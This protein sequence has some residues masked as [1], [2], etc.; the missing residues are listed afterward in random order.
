[1][2][3]FRYKNL[4]QG[5]VHSNQP[6]VRTGD[7]Y[8][9]RNGSAFWQI[10]PVDFDESKV[11]GWKFH[12]SIHPDDVSRAWDLIQERLVEEKLAAK[13]T[14]PA[15]SR[16]FANPNELQRGKMVTIYDDTS[17]PRDWGQLLKHIEDTFDKNNVRPGPQVNI[18]RPVEG[19]RFASYRNDRDLN[20]QYIDSC[21]TTSY[22][23]ANHPDP[24]DTLDLRRVAPAQTAAPRPEVA[25]LNALLAPM[26]DRYQAAQWA[27]DEG[28]GGIGRPNLRFRHP[29][30]ARTHEL[31]AS[32]E[33]VGVPSLHAQKGGSHMLV[34]W[35]DDAKALTADTLKRA[36]QH[37]A[38]T[39]VY[40][41]VARNPEGSP[42]AAWQVDA[43][44]GGVGVPNVRA[45]VNSADEA[46][47]VAARVYAETGPCQFLK[48]R[49][50]RCQELSGVV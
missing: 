29:D 38:A 5:L 7:Y 8:A 27:F 2:S 1:M 50:C 20:G 37:L 33:A 39:A 34:V 48:A 42:A 25:P 4:E 46:H 12:L 15:Y 6:I 32:L 19:S 10:S 3:S 24:Y 41:Q 18:D 17:R 43:G 16:A 23:Q 28:K 11:N 14:N 36:Q 26:G 22:N 44:K 31:A 45:Y 9:M 35:P 21:R 13:V 40:E 47:Q 49:F 30:P